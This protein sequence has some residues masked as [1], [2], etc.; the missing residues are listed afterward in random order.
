MNQQFWLTWGPIA[1][2]VAGMLY[3]WWQSWRTFK[4][5]QVND[6]AGRQAELVKTAMGMVDRGTTT[7]E[8]QDEE[9]KELKSALEKSELAGKRARTLRDLRVEIETAERGRLVEQNQTLR[10]YCQT[11]IGM[12]PADTNVPTL[13]D[14]AQH[15]L[16]ILVVNKDQERQDQ[17][18]AI[19]PSYP[20]VVRTATTI[21]DAESLLQ[22]VHFDVVIINWDV[23]TNGAR[24]YKT[25]Q[26]SAYHRHV[27]TILVTGDVGGLTTYVP[28]ELNEAI[29]TILDQRNK[30]A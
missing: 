16:S 9:I 22:T 20:C 15:K 27:V 3:S 25:I 17:I 7:I 30:E 5:N 2:T 8:E 19:T 29:A 12:L 23:P 28:I 13:P 24:V 26:Q 21:E 11:L 6:A 10:V 4:S 14:S 18:K 1:I